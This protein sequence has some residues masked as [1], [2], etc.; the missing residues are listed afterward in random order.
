MFPP[1][2]PAPVYG[3]GSAECA[4]GIFGFLWKRLTLIKHVANANLSIDSNSDFAAIHNNGRRRA[5]QQRLGDVS[6]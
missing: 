4:A 1:S 3:L 6:S 5:G 2:S